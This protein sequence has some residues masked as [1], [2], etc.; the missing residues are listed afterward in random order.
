MSGR[1]RTSKVTIARRVV[2][3]AVLAIIV[4]GLAV[5][6]GL[7]TLC[8]MGY[9]AIAAVCPLGALSSLL[10]GKEPVLRVVIALLVGLAVIIV[11]GKAFCSWVCPMPPLKT[12]LSTKK[13]RE[14]EIRER[15]ESAGQSLSAWKCGRERV[16]GEGRSC[17]SCGKASAKL[18]TRHAVLGGALLSTAV[19]GFPVFCLVCPIGL[20]VASFVALWHL[21]QFNEITIGL[22][23]FPVIVVLELV[24]F[25]K[26]CSKI[27]P[28]GAIL[29][30]VSRGNRSFVPTVDTTKCLRDVEGQH[31]NACASACP[32]LIDPCGDYGMRSSLECVKCHRCADACPVGAIAF[33]LIP[34][35]KGSLAGGGKTE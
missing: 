25:K 15:H 19:F 7:G 5:P 12:L 28:V 24:F 9:D 17:S 3:V 34:K 32:E 1:K 30:L 23:I 10:A 8:S 22:G 11:I 4:V 20:T 2:M 16:C 6:T 27:C 13:R 18:D 14:Q 21:V 35:K 26:W 29:S 31:C 33:P